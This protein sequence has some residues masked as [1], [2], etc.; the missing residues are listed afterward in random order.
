M[1]ERVL[2]VLSRYRIN[3]TGAYGTTVSFPEIRLSGKWLK[4]AGFNPGTHVRIEVSK[5]SLT[6]EK[7]EQ[8]IN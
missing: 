8:S 3:K 7:D 4:I 1:K 2:K 6:I 5:N